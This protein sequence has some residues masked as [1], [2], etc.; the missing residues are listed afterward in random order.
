M[1]RESEQ[2]SNEKDENLDTNNCHHDNELF[3]EIF[4][5]DTN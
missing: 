3:A 4:N 2:E 5:Y 1:K